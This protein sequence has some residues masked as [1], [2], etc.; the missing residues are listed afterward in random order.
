MALSPRAT[1][2]IAT[3]IGAAVYVDGKR[4]E[5]GGERSSLG[6]SGGAF[7]A[8]YGL[9]NIKPI[10]AGLAAA[11]YL[12]AEVF[13][14]SRARADARHHPLSPVSQGAL[15]TASKDCPTG[16]TWDWARLQC[17]CPPGHESFID[18]SDPSAPHAA[19]R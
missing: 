7:L 2:F 10:Y 18:W 14:P 16:M 9:S 8:I 15:E 6:T 4:R 11:T 12:A 5:A 3:T 13:L 17:I 19:C 1:A